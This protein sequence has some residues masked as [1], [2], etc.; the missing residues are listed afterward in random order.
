MEYGKKIGHS[1][2]LLSNLWKRELDYRTDNSGVECLTGVQIGIL[3]FI[4]D[5][6]DAGKDIYQKDIESTFKIRRS[7]VSVI[8]KTMDQHGLINRVSV[9]ADARLKKLIP[10]DL[11]MQHRGI[12]QQIVDGLAEKLIEDIDEA[13]LEAFLRVS[14][15]MIEYLERC[16]G[17]KNS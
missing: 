10:T 8:L 5:M 7:T 17:I 15:K 11:A 16:D 4:N 14:G 6:Y 3:E 1:V 12:T 13:D 9:N 2:R